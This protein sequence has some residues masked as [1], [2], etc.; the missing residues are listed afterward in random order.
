MLFFSERNNLA[1]LFEKWCKEN[2]AAICS[3][4]MVTFLETK[5]LLNEDKIKELLKEEKKC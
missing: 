1:K 3:V 4:N 2:N 5:G